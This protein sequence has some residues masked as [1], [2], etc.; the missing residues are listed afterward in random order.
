[1]RGLWESQ[2]RGRTGREKDSVE[3]KERNSGVAE[4][5]YIISPIKKSDGP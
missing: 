5:L 1:M 3:R 4:V 2:E